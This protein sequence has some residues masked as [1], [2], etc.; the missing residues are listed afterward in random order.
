MPQLQGD[1]LI[2]APHLLPQRAC[3]PQALGLAPAPSMVTTD[4]TICFPCTALDTKDS[5]NTC[6]VHA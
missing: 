4:G 2:S 1:T 5:A 3:P 6:E